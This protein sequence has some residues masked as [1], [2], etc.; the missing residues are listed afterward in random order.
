ML[1]PNPLD[2]GKLIHKHRTL[3]RLRKAWVERYLKPTPMKR[4]GMAVFP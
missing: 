3:S 4:E 2:V 1:L